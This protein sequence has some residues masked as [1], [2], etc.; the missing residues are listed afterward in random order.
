MEFYP[1]EP[2]DNNNSHN[3]LWDWIKEA[4]KDDLGVAF[5]RYPIFKKSGN[6]LR[7]P[8]VVLLHRT[9]GLWV[10]ECK[11][12]NISNVAAVQGHCWQMHNWHS[13]QESPLLQAEDQMF[14]IQNK[15]NSHRELRGKIS[16]FFRAAL[17]EVKSKEWQEKG[18]KQ[19]TETAVWTY[20][21]LTPAALKRGVAAVAQERP[22]ALDDRT[23]ELAI[24]ILGGTLP[25]VEPRQIPTTTPPISP[26]RVI[27][28]IESSLKV[29]DETQQKIAFEVPDGPQRLR[30]LAGTGKTVLFA[31][32]VAKLHIKYPNWDIGFIFFT[33]S[34]YDQVL[35]LITLYC[36]ELGDRDPNWQKIKVMHSWGGR[37][38]NGFYSDLAKRTGMTPLNVTDVKNQIG[39]T[40]PNESFEYICLS[41]ARNQLMKGG[42]S[43]QQISQI[44]EIQN[45]EPN[46]ILFAS[47]MIQT[48]YIE[49]ET[50]KIS[51]FPELYDALFVDEGQ[52]LPPICYK[53]LLSSLK[54]PKRLYWAYDE[55]QGIGSLTI[56]SSAA[57]FGRDVSG[58]PRVDVAG[59]YPGGIQKSHRMHRCY[60]TPRLL[61]MT[62][63]AL[64]MGLLRE[65]GA[66]QGVTTKDDWEALGYTITEGDF[67]VTSVSQGRNVT[68]TRDRKASPHPIDHESFKQKDSL[69]DVLISQ[70]FDSEIDEC[71]WIAQQVTKD[72]ELGFKPDDIII[73]ALSG[74]KEREYMQMLKEALTRSGVDNFIA[75]VDGD[76]SIFRMAGKVTISNIFRTKGN[77]AWKVYA[78][79]F[80][81]ANQPL[82]WK[83]ETDLQKRNEAFV[84]LTRTKV[85]CV[86]TGLEDAIFNELKLIIASVPNLTFKAFNKASLRRITEDIGVD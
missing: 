8:D 65:E 42:Y 79:R 35:E 80:H 62:A 7:E 73:T 56:P 18:F 15:L 16:Y 81:Y 30:G 49:I 45:L 22:Q 70:A 13:E 86:V 68:L 24:K 14:A 69:G 46:Q 6:L 66:L 43:T 32:R 67:S 60:R 76:R 17:P 36:Q 53:L 20:E 64:N 38:Q 71:D 51:L 59:T 4:F 39:N 40:G 61:L 75:G 28:E 58:K 78:C 74:N 57:M 34:L 21:D 72:L 19:H 3:K 2:F 84:A 12:C 50:N 25:R 29:L 11:G 23:W 41:L 31:K 1:Y 5:Y 37:E 48:A 33:R 9:Y 52:D 85:W 10:F 83:N 26:L 55:A 44:A 47:E 54:E 63:H 82:R 27:N 77:E